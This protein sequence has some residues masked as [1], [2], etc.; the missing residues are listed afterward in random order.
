MTNAA[1]RAQQRRDLRQQ[2]AVLGRGEEEESW[3]VQDVTR[4]RNWESLWSTESGEEIKLL[5]YHLDEYL[6]KQLPDG[7]PMFVARPEEAPPYREGR[8]KCF[9]AKD[10]PEREALNDLGIFKVCPAEKLANNF[11]KQMH[12]E[13]KHRTEWRMYSDYLA[14]LE[15]DADRERQQAQTEAMLEVARSS[16]RGPGR[17]PKEEVDA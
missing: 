12:A 2:I 3:E 9:M 11:A 13:H 6:N 10:S 1:I 16:R 4:H 5:S 7:R 8:T 14:N 17:P 15:K